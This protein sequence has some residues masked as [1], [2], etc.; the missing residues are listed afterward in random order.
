MAGMFGRIV[1]QYVEE[2]V[3]NKL[4]DTKTMQNLAVKGVEAGKA[5]AEAAKEP[6]AVGSFLSDV[7]KQLKEEAAKDLKAGAS[8]SSAAKRGSGTLS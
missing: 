2:I 5:V 6:G 3:V 7:F 8:S 4:S 1:R